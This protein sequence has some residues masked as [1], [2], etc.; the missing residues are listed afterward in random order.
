M[1]ASLRVAATLFLFAALSYLPSALIEAREAKNEVAEVEKGHWEA[2][3]QWLYDALTSRF[4][5]RAGEYRTAMEKMF[6]VARQSQQ[7]DAYRHGFVLA[8][9]ALELTG[10]EKIARDWLRRFPRDDQ[11]QL[12]LIRVYLMENRQ[13]LAYEQMEAML[14]KDATPRKIAQLARLL[15]YL[16]DSEQR[17]AMLKRLAGEFPKNP[18]LYYYLGLLAKEQGEVTEAIDAFDHALEL[19]GSW[20]QLQMI[21]AETLSAVGRLDEAR[22]II[23]TLRRR[24]PDDV[25]LLAAEIDM[26]VDH[27]QWQAALSLAEQWVVLDPQD[28]RIGQLLAWLYASSGAYEAAA[29]AYRALLDHGNIDE[30]QYHFQMARAAVSLGKYQEATALLVKIGKDSTLYMLARQ[31]IAL[32]AVLQSDVP[33][34]LRAFAAL[35]EQFP[36]YALEMYLVEISHL[37]RIGAH[38]AAGDRLEEALAQYPN[39]VDILYALAEHQADTGKIAEAEKTYRKI[40]TLDPDN[41]DALNAYG[42]LLL[43][44]TERK[45]EAEKMIRSAVARY[46]DSPAM[47]DSY[48]WMLYLGHQPRE[49]LI[50]LQRAYSAYRKGEIAAHYVEVLYANGKKELA[51]KVY[52]YERRGQ[53][54]NIHL[55]NTG[56]HLGFDTKP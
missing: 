35:R 32:M 5:D 9:D 29:Q 18:Y 43:T 12:A 2:S 54:E 31:Q 16:D 48:A 50:W 26:L 41:I 56:R 25:E 6:N 24:D 37:D 34:A 14:G 3:S 27:Y 33:K 20:R 21:Q 28:D 4:A 52:D 17:L 11:A 8:I 15:T 49:A 10:A 23:D 39:Q 7:Y 51:Q 42:Y 46:P 22:E 38:K 53:P 47:Q 40:L 30:D 19:D 55:Q 36:E 45:Q 13:A 44:R 1:F